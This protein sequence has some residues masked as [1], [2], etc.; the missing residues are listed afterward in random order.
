MEWFRHDANAHDDIKVRKL[1]QH[2]GLEA[3]G[4]Y[5][6]LV[7][8]IYGQGGSASSSDIDDALDIL[9][10]G[11]LRRPLEESRLFVI[12]EDG[13]WRSNRIDRELQTRE[14]LNRIRSE[15]GKKGA[16]SRWSDRSGNDGKNGKPMANDGNGI[17]KHATRHN[18]TEQDYNLGSPLQEENL[19][20]NTKDKTDKT[21]IVCSEPSS[22]LE[23]GGR[24]DAV[25]VTIISNTGE[26]IPI[27]ESLVKLWEQTYPA[28][29]VRQ[30]LQRMKSWAINNPKNRKTK[31]GMQ[32][33]CDNWL[34]RTQNE[35]RRIPQGSRETIRNSNVSMTLTA[36]GSNP[37]AYRNE[38]F[39]DYD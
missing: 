33:F 35:A 31:G 11:H 6:Y 26:E 36:D 7:E 22:G 18:K 24:K 19:L 32:R 37:D 34:A 13:T 23:A 3:Y 29:D 21:E 16:Q 1:I 4:V 9:D 14:E 10:A 30:E 38:R 17:A 20:I 15:A 12:T 25:F 8:L 5:W 27:T 2:H 28:V 39:E